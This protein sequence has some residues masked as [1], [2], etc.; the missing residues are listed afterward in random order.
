M[1]LTLLEEG[2]EDSELDEELLG[3]DGADELSDELLLDDELT[4]SLEPDD[5]YDSEL[6]D[7]LSDE[8]LLDEE[9]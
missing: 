9:D 4:D 3:V 7:E 2:C 1:L 6:D 5:E 8:L